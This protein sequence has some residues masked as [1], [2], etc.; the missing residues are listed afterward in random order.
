MGRGQVYDVDFYFRLGKALGYI[1]GPIEEQTAGWQSK[2]MHAGY[3]AGKAQKLAYDSAKGKGY[4]V[5]D[6]PLGGMA[7]K[8]PE[9]CHIE[10]PNAKR[11]CGC[12]FGQCVKGLIL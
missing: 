1:S 7:K 6:V 9:L 10:H 11:D 4:A 8:F 5:R 12:G 2:A 3:M